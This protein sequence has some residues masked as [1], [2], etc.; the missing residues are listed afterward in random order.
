MQLLL[1]ANLGLSN[2]PAPP[3]WCSRHKADRSSR[4]LLRTGSESHA[5]KRPHPDQN[6]IH[7]GVVQATPAAARQ[8]GAAAP[9]GSF[10]PRHRSPP[11]HFAACRSRT[12]ASAETPA[13][14]NRNSRIRSGVRSAVYTLQY[15]SNAVA[16]RSSPIHSRYSLPSA[17]RSG[18]CPQILVVSLQQQRRRRSA[19]DVAS[20]LDKL[21]ALAVAHRRV[22]DTLK[23]VH[24]LH[25]L[26]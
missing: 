19:L 7:A 16:D 20:H 14:S 24:R 5:D 15:A 25:H 11:A 21:P 17:I 23:L 13:S 10:R 4:E 3:G 2:P 26:L 6:L 9:R 22:A 18:C 1:R 12:A 8:A